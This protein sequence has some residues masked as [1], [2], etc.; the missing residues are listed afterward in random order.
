MEKGLMELVFILD[1]SGS[2][3][4]LE[5]DTIKGFNTMLKEQCMDKGR[6]MVTTV[7]FDDQYELLHNRIPLE[8][9]HPLT[10]AQYFV[11][12]CTALLDAIGKTIHTI[13]MHQQDLPEHYRAE[14]VIFVIT[15]DGL[16]N[17]SRFYSYGGIRE[18]VEG[19]KKKGWEF[20]FLGAN[21][22]AV[23]EAAKFGIEEDRA[24]TYQ[25]DSEG[26]AVNYQA[27]N[28]FIKKNRNHNEN[29]RIGAE[30]KY[31]VERNMRNRS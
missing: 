2:M 24:V 25:N 9:V 17:S 8:E 16:E 20:I 27:I 23:S 14:K 15:T 19:C 10:R 6:I 28:D 31:N 7:L 30:W 12:G 26:I 5:N 21:M 18:M 4:G 22:D 13:T 29:S 3:G 11:R 1:R